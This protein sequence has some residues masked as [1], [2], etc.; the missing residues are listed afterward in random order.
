MIEQ[1][2]FETIE[3]VV[4]DTTGFEETIVHKDTSLQ[5]LEG[6]MP[7]FL[8]EIRLIN[9]KPTLV[10][11]KYTPARSRLRAFING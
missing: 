3:I 9:P 6:S 4:Q 1:I 5:K 11:A 8:K 7:G 2:N 10:P